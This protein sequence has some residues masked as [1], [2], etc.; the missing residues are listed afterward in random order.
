MKK[1]DL[2]VIGHMCRDENTDP[3]GNKT[4]QV[5]SA[6]LCGAMAV[7]KCGKNVAAIVKMDP[8]DRDC[9]KILSENGIDM[10]IIPT[11][12]TSYMRVEHPSHNL[13]E[14]RMPLIHNAG[15][16]VP[17]EIPDFQAAKIHLASISDQEF[18][19]DL[20]HHLRS[21]L[22]G[23]SLSADMQSFVRRVDPDTHRV[24]YTVPD[25]P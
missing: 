25:E 14:R 7:V 19:L 17:E 6:M 1:Y 22:S 2:V 10:H 4:V 3:Q 24:S 16:I 18:S 15:R 9:T 21:P 13:D 11:K 23:G 5:G 20:I 8:E 12:E